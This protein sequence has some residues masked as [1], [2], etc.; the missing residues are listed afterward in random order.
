M[1]RRYTSSYACL[2]LPLPGGGGV[3]WYEAGTAGGWML[4]GGWRHNC[5]MPRVRSLSSLQFS[6]Q[7]YAT[8]VSR[9]IVATCK[10]PPPTPPAA[11]RS[12]QPACSHRRHRRPPARHQPPQIE[13]RSSHHRHRHRPRLFNSLVRKLQR[14]IQHVL[15]FRFDFASGCRCSD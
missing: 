13:G 10:M 9:Q 1:P 4:D 8:C 5:S 6:R 3:V 2:S 7:I 12:P 15:L 14:Y 11:A